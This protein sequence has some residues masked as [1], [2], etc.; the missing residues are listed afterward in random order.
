MNNRN[1]KMDEAYQKVSYFRAVELYN[2]GNLAEAKT[3][4]D[5]TIATPVDKRYV[6]LANYWLGEMAYSYNRYDVAQNYMQ[7]FLS[8]SVEKPAQYISQANY[9]LGYTYY[10]QKNYQQAANAFAKVSTGSFLPD[11]NLRAG[12]SNF[13]L[14]NYSQAQNYYEQVAN[15]STSASDYANLQIA[16]LNGLQGQTNTKLS[17]LQQLYT[18][19]PNSPYADDA[20]YE[21]A[22]VFV[23][24]ENY[25]QAEQSFNQLISNYPNSDQL[26]NA[27]N[28]LG[29]INYNQQQYTQAINYY[30]KIV[31]SYPNTEEAQTALTT[32]EEIYILQ[33]DP[34]SYFAYLETVSGINVDA[35]KRQ[36]VVY[37]A[38]ESQF[39]NGNCETAQTGFTNYISEY[40]RGTYASNAY[41]YRGECANQIG[42]TEQAV[43]D[44][45]AVINL[46]PNKFVERSL[47]RVA[48]YEFRS[49]N[50]SNALQHYLQLEQYPNSIYEQEVN[51]GI[52]QSYHQLGQ[53]ENAEAYASRVLSAESVDASIQTEAE[54]IVAMNELR[55]GNSERAKAAL[56][57]IANKSRN[58]IGA[59]ARYE[60]AN[61]Y[62]QAGLHQ[63]SIEACYRVADETPSEDDWV[64]KSF[65]LIADN[66][67]ALDEL[68]Q[69]KATLE[70]VIENYSGSDT[71][72]VQEAQRKRNEIIAQEE[73]NS[74]LLSDPEAGS[75]LQLQEN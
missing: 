39:Q 19:K 37:Q 27:Y 24:Q 29:L 4:F 63:Q 33:G 34:D 38:A 17:Q 62:F 46:A 10:N 41:F 67:L 3:L 47:I 18:Q 75:Q 20:L 54:F 45:E 69:A 35:D 30:D 70:S 52:M 12:D 25:G 21:Y 11:A 1:A 5:E 74:N 42:N 2:N 36:E 51:I 22:R 26:L 59:E 72:I 8:S 43:A 57:A 44:F 60:L 50:Y 14:R 65:I 53:R 16:I 66:Y 40:P 48:R 49:G 23:T 9:T 64:A 13:A 68:F 7:S 31:Q 28:Q 71:T 56:Q 15:Q 61:I 55:V 58:A 32:I 73:T 6:A